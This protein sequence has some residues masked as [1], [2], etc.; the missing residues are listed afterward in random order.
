M[1]KFASPFLVFCLI[2]LSIRSYSQTTTFRYS[3]DI[4]SFDI[5][6]G[7]VETPTG[8]FVVAGLN[9]TFVP[10]FGNV[11][12]LDNT[13]AVTWAKSYTG[14]IATNFTDIKNVS[15]GGYIVTGSSSNGGAV[16]V[17][18]DVS[19]NVTWAKRY[20][21][22]DKPGKASTEY[23][24]AVIETSDGGFL[25]GGGVDYFWDGVSANTVDTSSAMAFKVDASGTLVWNRV[26]TITNPT[27][28]DEHYINDV[29]ESAD[30]YFFV[31]ESADET[32]SYD[33]DGDL[34]RNAL[35]IKTAKAD[36]ALTYIRRWGAGNTS[37]QGIN[38]ART[39]STGNILLGGYDDVH[40][41]IVSISGTGTGTPTVIFNR[42]LNGS[43]FGSIYVVNDVM[44]NSDG[45]Y[46]VIGTQIAFLSIA[47]NTMIVKINSGT[48]ALMFGRSYAPIGLSAILPEGGLASDQGY[49]VAMTDQQAGGFNYNIIRT[50]NTG[51]LGTGATGCASNSLSPG[52]GTESITFSTPA[53]AN[54]TNTTEAA[55][56]P[57][58]NNLTPTLTQ[59]CLNTTCTPPAVA[60]TV[61]AT[62]ATIC[63]GQ[64][65]SITAS[66]PATGVTYN[67]YTASSGGT[68]VGATPVSVSPGVTTTYYVET[69]LNSNPTCVSTTRVPVTVTV[70]PL[71]TATAG[72]NSPICAG[73]T[74][75]L[76]SSGG[77]TYS[78][79][80][81]NAFTSTTQNPSI[82]GA[83]VAASGT[84]TVTVT[85]AGCSA[86]A[87]TS[88]TV[89]ASLTVTSGSNTPVCE[90]GTISL[91]STGGGTYSWTGPNAFTSTSQNPTLT[92]TPAAAGT[93]TVTVSASGCSATSTT[94]VNITAAPVV[95]TGSN[96]PV[97]E[98]ETISL[99]STGGGTYS[100]AGPNAFTSTSQNPTLTASAA[101]AGTYT[102][103]VTAAG[104]SAT[105]TTTV[106]IAP[107]AI[108]TAGSNTPVCAGTAIN[109][110]AASGG[111]TYSWTGPNGFT[112]SNQNPAIPSA[113]AVNA[114]TYTVTVTLGGCSA[115]GTTV[116]TIAA[117][118]VAVSGSNTPVCENSTISLTASGGATYAWSGPNGFNSTLQNPTLTASAAAAGTYTVTVS[119]S[120]CSTTDSTVVA[121]NPAPVATAG[122]TAA[123]VCENGTISLTSSGGGT[124]AWTGP[125]AFTSTAQ[126]TVLPA[127]TAAA[128]T[129]SVVVTSGGCSDTAQT[130]ITV[131]PAPPIVANAASTTVC[132]GGTIDLSASGGTSYSWT[133]PNSFTSTSATPSISGATAAA[134]GVYTVTGTLGSCPATDTITVSVLPPPTAA[135][136]GSTT[137]CAG[138]STTLTASGGGTY[139][140][141]TSATTS[142]ITVNPSTS[143]VYWVIVSVGSCT[144]S[145]GVNVTVNPLPTATAGSSS[146]TVCSG[147]SINLT[148][149]G[150]T[151]YAWSGPNAFSSS[152]QNPT[153]TGATTAA[154]GTYTVTVTG[155]NGCSATATTSIA[156]NASPTVSVAGITSICASSSTTLTASGGTAYSWDTGATTAA[157]TVSPATT[158]SYTVTVTNTAAC[159]S[160][161]VVTVFVSTPPVVNI[162]GDAS[163]CAGQGTTLTASGGTPY[164]WSTGATTPDITVAPGTTTSYTVT[165]GSGC[166]STATISVTVSPSPSVTL[167]G[168][169]TI[170]QGTGT[171][172]SASGGTSY[173]WTPSTGLSCTNCATP[174]ASPMMTTQYCVT[175]SN[176]AGCSDSACTYVVVDV[177]CGELFVPTA[178]S[179]NNDGENDMLYVMGSCIE[180]L[181]FA[182]FDRWGE[183]VFETTDPSIGWD[184]SFKGKA[185][186]A[187]VF[188]YY[189]KA[190]VK[191]VD[192]D[193]HGNITLV[194]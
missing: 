9:S 158:T 148:A 154:G 167:S 133:G 57:T 105:S 122:S 46:S 95:T 114:G 66:G 89:N 181:N 124:Y 152:T 132:A 101:A 27:K 108:A 172:L 99:T 103:T 126:N 29:A 18:L 171:T 96:T 174:T 15:T 21:L 131:T 1:K 117:A 119:I 42:R 139:S 153:I 35:I 121:I 39:L 137:I 16:L 130:S 145:T 185:L 134:S 168:G 183:K 25:V 161:Q 44:E 80:G 24:N 123:T 115:T 3:Y 93:Y 116:V 136:A 187:A 151:G 10:F 31:G 189:L 142:S 30:G 65:S 86:T 118:P 104:C 12:K 143:T 61:T 26:W 68:L 28:A 49:Y 47:L 82:T 176:A 20:Q 53:T 50:D 186:D 180:D 59:H 48:G 52:L 37:S 71:P 109:L 120:G 2:V 67:V 51:Q 194:K 41:F 107:A 138:S 81:P 91:T 106:V 17:R 156:V 19:G 58:V 169:T 33:S 179:P 32:Q 56:T 165:A 45:N 113:S 191:G 112:D 63:A 110:T 135:I 76:T 43:V 173:S 97:C 92:A 166:T 150:G 111:T 13:G 72:S 62:P 164:L 178:F 90:N 88:V 98:N 14:G 140:W 157:I 162:T 175:A 85:A 75:N 141:S 182:I 22:P 83:T 170:I 7:M 177:Q 55:F 11:F 163:I 34:P 77:G 184:G 190:T 60:T 147:S 36:G 74:L 146:S 160:T 5:A 102:V 70:N 125:N 87:T 73:G 100:W 149:S 6:G 144:D 23:G 129:Y 128:G 54:Y 155:A 78:W 188:V 192:V 84:Y 193:K 69:S 40:S 4:A 64:S 8:D 127:I 79:A 38:A 159:S 94:T